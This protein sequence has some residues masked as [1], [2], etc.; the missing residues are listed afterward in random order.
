[1]AKA[2]TCFPIF[3]GGGCDTVYY[4]VASRLTERPSVSERKNSQLWFRKISSLE[5]LTNVKARE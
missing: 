1:M 3:R 5:R 4:H 2:C